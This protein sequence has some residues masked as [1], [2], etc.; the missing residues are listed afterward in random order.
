VVG[1]CSSSR[2]WRRRRRRHG[3][4][5]PLLVIAKVRWV[6]TVISSSV[7]AGTIT[8]R[9]RHHCLTDCVSG[10]CIPTQPG[11]PTF[12]E[13]ISDAEE[14]PD[15]I[16]CLS[17]SCSL[18]LTH[19]HSAPLRV[20]VQTPVPSRPVYGLVFFFSP[21]L[22]FCSSSLRSLAALAMRGSL[23]NLGCIPGEPDSFCLEN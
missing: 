23:E 12:Q 7:G 20:S 1:S 14:N 5:A 6:G 3:M 10:C 15:K 18:S 4:E 22:F 11:Q 9:L 19:A 17:L 16:C 2:R 13:I 21:C 8:R